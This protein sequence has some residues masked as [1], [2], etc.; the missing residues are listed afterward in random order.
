[1]SMTSDGSAVHDAERDLS[2][3]Q[4]PGHV[5]VARKTRG[6]DVEVA[7]GGLGEQQQKPW[8]ELSELS[9]CASTIAPLVPFWNR[10]CSP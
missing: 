2:Q 1:M 7:A 9:M 3:S 4:H 10:Q 6:V 8:V 5:V